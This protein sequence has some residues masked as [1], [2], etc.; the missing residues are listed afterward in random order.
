MNRIGFTNIMP[1]KKPP[2]GVTREGEVELL[3]TAAC[4]VRRVAGAIGHAALSQMA[5][6]VAALP[7]ELQADFW[8]ELMDPPDVG[9]CL[10]WFGARHPTRLWSVRRLRRGCGVSLGEADVLSTHS[11]GRSIE[12]SPVRALDG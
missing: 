12:K 7:A 3:G 9:E 11:H 4:A 6:P 8:S 1:S 2:R 10:M 5:R